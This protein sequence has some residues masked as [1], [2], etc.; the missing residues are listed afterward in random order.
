MIARVIVLGAGGHGRVVAEALREGGVEIVGFT[1]PSDSSDV[2]AIDGMPILGGDEVLI[3]YSKNDVVL[4][5]GIG[6]IGAPGLRRR[7]QS[8]LAQAGW[9]FATVVH[10]R[11]VLSKSVELG[12]GAQ[13]MAGAVVQA[14]T[15]VGDGCIINSGAIVDHDC[16]IGAF[17][18]VASGATLSGGVQ[19]AEESHIGAG[20]TIIQGV[21]ISRATVVGAGAVVVRNHLSG[22]TIVGVPA[23]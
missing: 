19:I 7:I 5:N 15:V 4:A 22:G 8:E 14:G 18:H 11:A 17:C 12:V 16:W 21:T 9:R 10:P 23:K 3:G 1:D 2:G 20:A 13:V 6:S